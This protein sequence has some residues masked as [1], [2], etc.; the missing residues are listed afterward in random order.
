ME[1]LKQIEDKKPDE[2]YGMLGTLFKKL[3][4]FKEPKPSSP[5]CE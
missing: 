3:P 4:G 1:G 2:S 5:K